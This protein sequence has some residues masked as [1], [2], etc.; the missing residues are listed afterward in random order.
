MR[1]YDAVIV[2]KF[3]LSPRGQ[4]SKQPHHTR[5]PR[6]SSQDISYR[7]ER[8]ADIQADSLILIGRVN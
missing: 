3:G 2:E 1:E 8:T 7:P 4:Q 5:T 6:Q